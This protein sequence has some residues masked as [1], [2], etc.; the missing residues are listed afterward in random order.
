MFHL[1]D[2]VVALSIGMVGL[3]AVCVGGILLLRDPLRAAPKKITRD[4]WCP[5]SKRRATVEFVEELKTGFLDR[6]VRLCSLKQ[7]GVHCHEDC[8]FAEMR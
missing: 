5:T 1:L 3:L 8:C 2:P 7:A 6:R 4:V